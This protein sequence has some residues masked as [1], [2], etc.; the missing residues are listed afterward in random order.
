MDFEECDD[1]SELAR[2]ASNEAF[3]INASEEGG[4]ILQVW[5]QEDFPAALRILKQACEQVAE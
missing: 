2:D 3:I 1:P 5:N 4:V